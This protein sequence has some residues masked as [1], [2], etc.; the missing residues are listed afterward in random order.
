MRR[1]GMV[2]RRGSS[3]CCTHKEIDNQLEEQ[4]IG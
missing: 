2:Y 3:D 4:G 1:L